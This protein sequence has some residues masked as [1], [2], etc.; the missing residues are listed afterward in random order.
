MM[1]REVLKLGGVAAA[2]LMMPGIVSAAGPRREPG[3][4]LIDDRFAEGRAFGAA[5]AQGGARVVA[6]GQDMLSL[7]HGS[8]RGASLAGLCGLTTYSDMVVI[9]GLAAEARRSFAL[10]IEHRAGAGGTV[11]RLVDGPPASLSILA[12]AA[13]RWP[14]GLWSVVAGAGNPPAA[15]RVDGSPRPA[16]RGGM[17][18]S[19]GIA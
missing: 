11:H 10:R 9:A 15:R 16:G 18:W 14:A 17:L 8:L 1:R 5:A 13:D 6:T 12:A 4:V 7:W 19:W 3:L 2:G